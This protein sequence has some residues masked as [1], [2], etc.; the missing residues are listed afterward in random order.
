MR[1]ELWRARLSSRRPILPARE[2]LPRWPEFRAAV[3]GSSGPSAS[4]WDAD[5]DLTEDTAD[6]VADLPLT[7]EEPLAILTTRGC[8]AGVLISAGGAA[9]T[10]GGAGA[11]LLI[12]EDEDLSRLGG[13]PPVDGFLCRDGR[14]CDDVD[15]RFIWLRLLGVVLNRTTRFLTGLLSRLFA[16]EVTRDDLPFVS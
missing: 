13:R 12:S 3:P 5:V 4:V 15:L 10:G 8:C 7:A 16:G 6:D 14:D 9:A 11:V 2:T 1:I